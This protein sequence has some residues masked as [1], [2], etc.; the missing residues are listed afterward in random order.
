MKKSKPPLR[1]AI[2]VF[3][4]LIMG[5]GEIFAQNSNAA[6]LRGILSQYM[7]TSGQKFRE[8]A[9][10]A[11]S[12]YLPEGGMDTL[13]ANKLIIGNPR[14]SYQ[15]LKKKKYLR[16]VEVRLKISGEMTADTT[17]F[18]SDTLSGKALRNINRQSPDM[19]RAED[20]TM[21]G[22]WV[23]PLALIVVSAGGVI[24]LFYIRSTL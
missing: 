13:S 19:L 12:E 11:N 23:K 22:K 6:I 3:V 8:Y 10:F 5:R 24:S 16:R 2:V 21:L 14:V 9:G 20:P 15:Y 17:L 4:A 1:Y 18:Y 7:E